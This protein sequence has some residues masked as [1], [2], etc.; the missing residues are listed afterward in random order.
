VPPFL[1]AAIACHFFLASS[2]ESVLL[3]EAAVMPSSWAPFFWSFTKE[4]RGLTTRVSPYSMT[5][6]S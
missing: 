4:I 1:S 3:R 6:G 5:A 2:E